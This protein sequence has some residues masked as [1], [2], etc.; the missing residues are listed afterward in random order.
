MVKNEEIKLTQYADDGTLILDGSR[1]SLKACIQTLDNFYEAACLKLNDK[2]TEALWIGSKRG[3][4][5]V[6]LP[7]RNF[8]WRNHKV[9]ALVVWLSVDTEATATL[10]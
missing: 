5:E 8:K 2:K 9:K 1:E 7:E 4:S 6:L 10:N 3:S